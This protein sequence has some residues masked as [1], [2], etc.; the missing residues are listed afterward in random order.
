MFSPL[1]DKDSVSLPLKESALWLPS[2]RPLMLFLKHKTL[3]QVS[4]GICPPRRR[5]INEII[6]TKRFPRKTRFLRGLTS[7]NWTRLRQVTNQ[8]TSVPSVSSEAT[9]E[10]FDS[11]SVLGIEFRKAAACSQQ[12]NSEVAGAADEKAH[13]YQHSTL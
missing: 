1:T 6:Q 9:A 11:A 13:S 4:P 8:S 7:T 12:S 5:P 10:R 2:T 3:P